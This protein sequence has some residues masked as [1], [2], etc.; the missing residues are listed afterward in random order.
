MPLVLAVFFVLFYLVYTDVKHRTIREFNNEQL[1]LAQT[2]A[3]GITSFFNEY[4][5][6]LT[7]LS[8]LPAIIENTEESHDLM[9]S[10]FESHKSRIKAFTR[11]DSTGIIQCTFPE[12]KT[13]IGRNISG[14]AHFRE[15]SSTHRPTIS[16]VFMSVQGYL[17]IALH[18]P[19][20]KEE[21]FAGSLAILISI[22]QLGK[23]YLSKIKVKGSGSVW[24]LSQNGVEIFCP[25]T[26]HT[27]RTYLDNSGNDSSAIRLIKQI[28]ISEKGIATGVHS[29]PTGKGTSVT[30]EKYMVFYRVPLG[31][32]YWTILISYLKQDVF[33]ELATLRNRLILIFTLLFIT[34][35]SYFYSLTKVRNVLNEQ[36]KREAAEKTLV[37]SELKFRTI[38]DEAPIGIELYDENG[39]QVN[40]NK[41]AL[42]LFGISDVSEIQGFNIFDR[43]SLTQAIKD[44]L[45]RGETVMYQSVFDFDKVKSLGQYQ[46]NRSGKAY[47]DYIITPLKGADSHTIKGYLLQVQDISERKRAE[48]EILMLA[49]SLRSIKE[50]VS[51]TDINDHILFVNESFLRTYGYSEEELTGKHI[52]ILMSDKT[53]SAIISEILPATLK[54]GWK[55]ELINK[56]KDGSEFPIFLS[57]T[58]IKDKAG[59]ILGLIGVA[60]DI[61]ENKRK[62]EELL[63]SIKK[64]EESDR[65]KSAFLANMSHEIRTPM[66]GILGFSDLLKMPG[67]TGE[68]QGNY[69]DIITKSGNRML[70]IINDIIDISKIE[71]GQMDIFLSETNINEQT[72]FVLQ[73]FKPE[74]HVKGIQLSL[75]NGLHD[76]ESIII[77]DREKLNAVLTNLV[78]NAIKYTNAGAIEM[79]YALKSGELE[80]FVKDTGIGIPKERQTAIFERFIQ[81]DISDKMARQ[82][83]GLGLAIAKSYVEM[84]GGTIWVQSEPGLGSVFYF[85]LPCQKNSMGSPESGSPAQGKTAV[86]SSESN[87]PHLKILIAEDDEISLLLLTR[88]V[89][90]YSQH[91]YSVHRG[92]DAVDFCRSNPDTDLILMDIQMPGMNGYEAT[93]Q[94]RQLNQQVIIIAQTAYG[95]LGD[96]EKAIEAGCNDYIPKPI[97]AGLLKELIQQYFSDPS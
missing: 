30:D 43:T 59:Q 52:G 45:K 95:M 44:K 47:F 51:I 91:T 74:A 7:F 48:E 27:G 31:N 93:R 38:F 15:V 1:I 60:S 28:G 70:N 73:F 46:T 53:P 49:H 78:K 8:R 69:I 68:Q 77:T 96:K 50:C 10:F 57:T 61:T 82:G 88:I 90:V 63:H 86:C 37:E 66:N 83:A 56:R 71:S 81:S 12:T 25:D 36:R 67:L 87:I 2:A 33:T 72:G 40:A 62:E 94:I 92:D 22:D 13:A 55:G 39:F 84:L 19:V 20:F 34:I 85:T 42:S 65:L 58:I 35:S 18:V 9:K 3:Q 80:F 23:I 21:K 97:Q 17:A 26:V 14:Q 6:D 64:A 16:D 54:G 24:M 4:Q 76:E 89:E 41:A 75:R 11:V 79:G 5:S 29:E 32:T